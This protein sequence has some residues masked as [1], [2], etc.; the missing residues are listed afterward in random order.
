[1]AR[2]RPGSQACILTTGAVDSHV[3]SHVLDDPGADGGALERFDKDVHFQLHLLIFCEL[4][5]RRHAACSCSCSGSGGAGGN[6]WDIR[7]EESGGGAA[8]GKVS[9]LGCLP[10]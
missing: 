2:E 4:Q 1:M 3:G 5:M 10:I 8:G 6:S 9:N 7:A